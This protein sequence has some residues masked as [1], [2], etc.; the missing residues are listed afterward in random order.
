MFAFSTLV[1]VTNQGLS[2]KPAR[3]TPKQKRCKNIITK[4]KLWLLPGIQRRLALF[5]NQRMEAS[6]TCLWTNKETN[7]QHTT[8]HINHININ[9]AR[10]KKTNNNCQSSH[11]L[12]E[13]WQLKAAEGQKEL[14]YIS[15]Y[16]SKV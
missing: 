5:H 15:Y 2:E 10:N 3:F 13:F 8:I 9:H 16:I 6:Q 1:V 12:C 14:I 4:V 11:I 7:N